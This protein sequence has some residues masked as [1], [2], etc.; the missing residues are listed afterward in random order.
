MMEEGV[1]IRFEDGGCTYEEWL[2]GKEPL[3][4]KDL[5]CPYQWCGIAYMTECKIGTRISEC[6]NRK[7]MKECWRKYDESKTKTTH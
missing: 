7:N 1:T 3:P 4:V 6:G 2:N 5:Y